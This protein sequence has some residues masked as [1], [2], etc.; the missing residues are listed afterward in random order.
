MKENS[1]YLS[2]KLPISSLPKV[3]KKVMRLHSHGEL[4][5]DNHFIN[6]CNLAKKNENVL[7]SLWTKR[8]EIISRHKDLIPSNLILIYSTPN[9][10]ADSEI[11]KHFDKSFTVYTSNYASWKDIKINCSGKCIDCLKCYNDKNMNIRELIKSDI[12]A[13]EKNNG[14]RSKEA[15]I[16][17]LY[18][19][20]GTNGIADLPS[21]YLAFPKDEK[22]VI[23]ARLNEAVEKTKENR[24]FSYPFIRIGRGLYTIRGMSNDL[25]I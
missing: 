18:N 20:V 12:I 11:P 21:L 15:L 1:N 10:N 16:K 24:D 9:L 3:E 8:P 5:N 17:R 7:F 13:E 2:K 6:F 22:H 25:Y 23:R 4:I 14:L 19:Y